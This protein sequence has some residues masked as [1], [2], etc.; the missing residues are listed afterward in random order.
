MR[1]GK[2]YSEAGKMGAIASLNSHHERKNKR[3]IEYLKNPNRCLFCNNELD[4]E[5]RK[6]IFCN[7]SCAA[8]FNNKKRK[9]KN[10]NK[11]KC[12]TIISNK[13]KHCLNCNTILNNNHSIFC[14]P[15]CMQDYNWKL[16]KI[17]IEKNGKFKSGK[18]V[19]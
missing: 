4:Y 1:N 6:L 16:R 11:N 15:Q 8:S 3:I 13:I 9:K 18:M 7:K 5:H 17:D 10:V 14:C 12:K 19:K 2:T